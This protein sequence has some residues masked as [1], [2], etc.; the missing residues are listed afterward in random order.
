M[1][2]LS[3]TCQY[4]ICYCLFSLLAETDVTYWCNQD[5]QPVKFCVLKHK[6]YIVVQLTMSIRIRY[7]T[8]FNKY[9]TN[10]NSMIHSDS[11]LS[12]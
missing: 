5:L 10:F 12:H 3:R 4:S 11:A 9:D 8:G 7:Q 6:L 2:I 1:G